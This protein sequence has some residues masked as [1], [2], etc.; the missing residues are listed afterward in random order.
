MVEYNV[1][2]CEGCRY[3]TKNNKCNFNLKHNESVLKEECLLNGDC[4]C[5]EEDEIETKLIEII[6]QK[7]DKASD[8]ELQEALKIINNH[9]KKCSSTELNTEGKKGEQDEI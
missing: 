8:K 6:K 5:Y 7:I 4:D 1:Y 3:L 2:G 9:L